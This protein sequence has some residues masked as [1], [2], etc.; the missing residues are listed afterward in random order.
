MI[1]TIH[2]ANYK[3]YNIFKTTGCASKRAKI[4]PSGASTTYEQ[5]TF[6]RQGSNLSTSEVARCISDFSITAYLENG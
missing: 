1:P 4:W 2:V 3:M 5:R 6:D